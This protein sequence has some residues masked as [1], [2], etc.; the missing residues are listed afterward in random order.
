MLIRDLISFHSIPCCLHLDSILT[1]KM[2]SEILNKPAGMGQVLKQLLKRFMTISH[3]S[4]AH[5]H[6]VLM[7][8]QHG[9]CDDEVIIT[10]SGQNHQ[11]TETIRLKYLQ[12]TLY[13]L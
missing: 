11:N 4:K 3:T 8:T 12:I 1:P 7:E 13:T 2:L 6:S 9:N 10:S 5:T